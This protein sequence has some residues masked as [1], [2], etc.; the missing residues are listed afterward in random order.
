MSW[1]Y[2]YGLLFQILRGNSSDACEIRDP[3]QHGGICISTD[4]GPICE[5]R[6]PDY[7]GEFCEKGEFPSVWR[8]LTPYRLFP[9]ERVYTY[10]RNTICVNESWRPFIIERE[11]IPVHYAK[12]ERW[13]WRGGLPAGKEFRKCTANICFTT[14]GS[15]FVGDSGGIISAFIFTRLFLF[16]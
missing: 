16:C 1:N 13:R 2:G 4:S 10:D 3:C 12:N 15:V 14:V 9:R 11:R 6:N 5:C 8:V 7:E